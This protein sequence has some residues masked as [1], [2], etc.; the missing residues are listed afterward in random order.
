MNSKHTDF[1]EN[2]VSPQS[3]FPSVG[4]KRVKTQTAAIARLHDRVHYLLTFT[5]PG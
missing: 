1:C 5:L 2:V 4:E 3:Q